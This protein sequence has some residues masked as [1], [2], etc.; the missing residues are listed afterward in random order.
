[1]LYILLKNCKRVIGKYVVFILI[2][3]YYKIFNTTVDG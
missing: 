2:S 3:F 1:M